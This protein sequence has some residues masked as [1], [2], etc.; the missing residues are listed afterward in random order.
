MGVANAVDVSNFVLV[1]VN[2]SSLAIPYLSFGIPVVLGDSGVIDTTS[3][4]RQYANLQGVAADFGTVAPE[5]LA[6]QAFFG[7]TPQPNVIFVGAWA[8]TAT[9]GILLCA[10]LTPLQQLISTWNALANGSF[11]I[12]IDAVPH[13]VTGLNFSTALNMPG[14]A[15]IIQA[16][17]RTIFT[18]ALVT[19]VW[20]AAIGQFIFGSSTTGTT[21]SV[22]LLTTMGTL[23]GSTDVSALLGGTLA[24]GAQPPVLG[25]AAETPLAAVLAAANVSTQWY[26]ATFAASVMPADSDVEAVALYIL[27]SSRTRL[28]GVTIQ[29]VACLN[30]AITNDL[31]SVLQSFNNK[32]VFWIYSSASPYAVMSLMARA[33]TVNFNGSLTTLTLAYKQL[34]GINSENL[35]QTQFATLVAKGGNVNILVNNGAIMAWPGQM[36]NG[37][38]F[39]EVHGVDW[40]QNRVQTDLFN[41]LYQTTTKVPQTDAGNHLMATTIE[42]SCQAGIVNGLG[43]PGQWNAAGFGQLNQGDTLSKGFYVYAPLIASQSQ[44]LRETRVSV[45]FQVAFKL[46]GAVHQP[47]V[48]LNIN[49]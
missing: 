28:Y 30:P 18:P 34:P 10:P 6:A 4:I 39:D 44:A 46:A 1:Q 17:L 35:T 37:V 26:V 31:A 9:A 41:L 29:S 38:F 25:V 11:H 7:Q 48:I 33:L 24:V 43:A 12:V 40:L 49:R 5:Y 15:A 27:G 14:I 3:R 13:D 8:R 21:S 32:R 23:A 45:P 36:S 2:I 47:Q 19:C 22:S 16:G 20:N 42:S